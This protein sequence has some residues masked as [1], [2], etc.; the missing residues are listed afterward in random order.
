[1]P[2]ARHA[3]KSGASPAPVVYT[4][5]HRLDA[6]TKR[7]QPALRAVHERHCLG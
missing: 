2:T 7:Y 3:I 5:G 1:M 6:T 4:M